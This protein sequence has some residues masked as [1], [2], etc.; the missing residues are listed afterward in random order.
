[1][2]WEDHIPEDWI[3]KDGRLWRDMSPVE[4]HMEMASNNPS[5]LKQLPRSLRI[6]RAMA[7]V[8]FRV[9]RFLGLVITVHSK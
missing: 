9:E 1:M 7:S 5:L 4:R 6:K 2:R 8:R 3:S